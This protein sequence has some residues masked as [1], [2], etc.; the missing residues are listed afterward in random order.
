MRK[1]YSLAEKLSGEEPE[2]T[3]KLFMLFNILTWSLLAVL[4]AAVLGLPEVFTGFGFAK[5]LFICVGYAVFVP[6]IIAGCVFLMRR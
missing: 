3:V 6:G 2:K 4:P 5:M 1:M